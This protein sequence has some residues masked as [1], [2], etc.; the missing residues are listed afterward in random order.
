V[1]NRERL[2]SRLSQ[3]L[4]PRTRSEVLAAMENRGIPAG[5][6]NNLAD[7][8]SDPQVQHRALVSQLK[9]PWSAAGVVPTVRT[10]VHFSGARLQLERPAPLLGEHTD[11]VRKEIGLA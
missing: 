10:P 1:K 4:A 8:F 6:I 9:A 3:L 2:I 11:E 5:P 7:V